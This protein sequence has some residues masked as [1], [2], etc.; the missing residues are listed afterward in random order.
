[1]GGEQLGQAYKWMGGAEQREYQ[2]YIKSD[3]IE[4]LLKQ[5][6]LLIELSDAVSIV[7]NPNE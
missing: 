3:W 4:D 1:M 6:G 5:S 2:S 7:I